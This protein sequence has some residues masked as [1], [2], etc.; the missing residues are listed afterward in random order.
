MWGVVVCA[1]GRICR[2]VWGVQVCVGSAGACGRG[3][4]VWACGAGCE[5]P[6]GCKH[7]FLQLSKAPCVGST[8]C[9]QLG[10][11]EQAGPCGSPGLRGLRQGPLS[12]ELRAVLPSCP[13]RGQLL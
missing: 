7:V 6:R 4:G 12:Q 11:W 8:F 1:G 10:S 3:S 9:L 13:Q 2:C 5:L